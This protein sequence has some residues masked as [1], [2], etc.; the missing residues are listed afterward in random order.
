MV[1]WS[2]RFRKEQNFE[3]IMTIIFLNIFLAHQPYSTVNGLFLTTFQ[4]TYLCHNTSDI[5]VPHEVGFVCSLSILLIK[6]I[7]EWQSRHNAW[8]VSVFWV[9]PVRIFRRSDQNN[10]KYGHFLCSVIFI[11]KRIQLFLIKLWQSQSWLFKVIS[12]APSLPN[13][14]FWFFSSYLQQ[15]PKYMMLCA[16]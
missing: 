16:I 11:G 5:K 14:S 1:L 9:I 8:K 10:S 6:R 2:A 13:W 3:E 4:V 12:F 7:E 15:F